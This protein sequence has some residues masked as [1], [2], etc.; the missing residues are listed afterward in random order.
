MM[1][2]V[3]LIA[4]V[5]KRIPFPLIKVVLRPVHHVLLVVH[6]NKAVLNVPI[7]HL[8]NSQTVTT[9]N[10]IHVRQDGIR[11]NWMLQNVQNVIKVK[12]HCKANHVIRVMLDVLEVQKVLAVHV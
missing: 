11:W 4:H 10:A 3:P 9:T 2:L 5:A 1:L 12:R 7:V 6:P 8:V